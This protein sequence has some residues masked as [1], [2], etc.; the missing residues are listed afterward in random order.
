MHKKNIV[1]FGATG[2]IGEFTLN[3][4]RSN[5][6]N[7]NVV[8]ITCYDNISKVVQIANEFDCKNIGIAKKNLFLSIKS[9]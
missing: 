6:Q 3:L 2:S 8:G 5:K 7:F 4:I 1:I 9:C